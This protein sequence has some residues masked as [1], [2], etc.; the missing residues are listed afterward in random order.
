MRKLP[1]SVNITR[2]PEGGRDGGES[3]KGKV[4]EG[5]KCILWTRPPSDELATV[6]DTVSYS[7]CGY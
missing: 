6:E 1:L 4:R 5:G 2:F 7:T 3:K